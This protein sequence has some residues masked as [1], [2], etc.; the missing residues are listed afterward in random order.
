MSKAQILSLS[1]TTFSAGAT[2]LQQ[3]L[4]MDAA[5][6]QIIN[7][8]DAAGVIAVLNV[9]L[10]CHAILLLLFHVPIVVTRLASPV[11]LQ[12]NWARAS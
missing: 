2:P 10:H 1:A 9:M 3:I 4:I 7:E 6:W 5:A 8:D 11:V 12:V